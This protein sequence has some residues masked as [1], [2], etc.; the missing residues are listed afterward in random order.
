MAE[1]KVSCPYRNW[2]IGNLTITILLKKESES[3]SQIS[4][5]FF[6]TAQRRKSKKHQ[7]SE[8]KSSSEALVQR[9]QFV[10]TLWPLQAENELEVFFCRRRR[11]FQSDIF[12]L[13][14]VEFSKRSC[15]HCVE[16]DPWF[17]LWS[18]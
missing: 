1:N 18:I 11:D 12:F 17:C 13:F 5:F 4:F 15:D 9:A 14:S 10:K 8:L 6:H 7:K 16:Q 2:F 3:F